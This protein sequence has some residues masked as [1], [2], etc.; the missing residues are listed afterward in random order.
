MNFVV[1]FK[2]VRLIATLIMSA[3]LFLSSCA[4]TPADP[5]T[6]SEEESCSRIKA[7]IADHRSQFKNY[8]RSLRRAH[9]LNTWS[10]IKA[11][12]EAQQCQIWE[13]SSGLYNYLCNW[14]A[15][16]GK[17][18]AKQDY[19]KGKELI[20][21]CLGLEW[22]TDIKPT[23]SGGER[24]VFFQAGNK[25]IVAI[26]YLQESRSWMNRW[27]TVVIIGDKNNLNAKLQ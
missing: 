18:S 4:Q 10:A 7:L 11:F 1:N 12:P 20:K 5:D 24:T 9:N 16:E 2:S 27:H 17:E 13:W 14:E 8:K 15:K 6:L 26:R 22:R 23:K 25:T 19:I 21:N 3:S